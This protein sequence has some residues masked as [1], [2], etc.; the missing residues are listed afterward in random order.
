MT[1]M[2]T[3]IF[4]MIA[5][6]KCRIG[7]YTAEADQLCQGLLDRQHA[8]GASC[9]DY[10][11]KLV[12]VSAADEIANTAS[13]DKDFDSRKAINAV[14][15]RHKSLMNDGKQCERQLTANLRLEVRWK[16]IEDATDGL[17]SIVRVHR[18][19]DEM[20]SLCCGHC[21]SHCL[22]ISD[23]ADEDDIGILA[24]DGADSFREAVCVHS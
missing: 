12:I 8:L 24:K 7:G 17:S 6:A 10:G 1:H 5:V 4:G 22:A 9:L 3:E 23:F 11:A 13:R 20:S 2:P 14:R 19:E 18:G 16:Y 15:C 21:G